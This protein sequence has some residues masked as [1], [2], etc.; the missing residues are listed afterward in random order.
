MFC[1]DWQTKMI[2]RFYSRPFI[3]STVSLVCECIRSKQRVLQ[4]NKITEQVELESRGLKM[5]Q[6]HCKIIQANTQIK[7]GA[8][9]LFH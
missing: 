5:L 1:F 9:L 8:Q 7:N 3:C 2:S 6:L 4:S